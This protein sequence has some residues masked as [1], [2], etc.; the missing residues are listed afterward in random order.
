MRGIELT[1]LGGEHTFNL[2][3]GML[4]ALQQRCDAGP[5]HIL[6]RLSTGTWLVDDVVQTIRL[7]LE[8]GGMEKDAARQLVAQHVEDGALA[9]SVITA[10]LVLGA[11]IYGIDQGD[12]VGEA[13]GETVAPNPISP[14]VNGA[15]AASTETVS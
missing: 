12:D 13:Q 3:I 9:L 14:A 10:R 7:G 4:R 15:S 11:A 8:G 6:N 1:W 2:P 5:Q